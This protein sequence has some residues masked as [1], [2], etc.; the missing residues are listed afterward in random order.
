[1]IIY[2]YIVM[3]I[4][5]NRNIRQ[6]VIYKIPNSKKCPVAGIENI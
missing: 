2:D 6:I 3:I 1:M 4:Y 5:H